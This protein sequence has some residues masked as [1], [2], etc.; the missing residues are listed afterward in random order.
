MAMIEVPTP[1]QTNIKIRDFSALAGLAGG[2]SRRGVPGIPAQRG[3]PFRRASKTPWPRHRRGGA[4]RGARPRHWPFPTIFQAPRRAPSSRRSSF[5]WKSCRA[6]ASL[7]ATTSRSL[8]DLDKQRTVSRP[9]SIA[10]PTIS[11]NSIPPRRRPA[12]T[13]RFASRER[14]TPASMP[15]YD[16]AE[17]E[18]GALAGTR[19]RT[20]LRR[21]SGRCLLHPCPG[22]G[23]HRTRRGWRRCASPMR[24]R[25]AIPTRR[26]DA[27]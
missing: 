12:S 3:G 9:R 4:Y 20:R 27:C 16:R 10:R 14:P 21:R 15:Y 26:S 5:R 2:R 6:P 1:L 13:R 22:G 19:P 8:P 11:S 25:P 17:I 18:A 23:P 7:P 24:R